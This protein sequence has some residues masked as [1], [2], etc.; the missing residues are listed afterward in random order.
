MAGPGVGKTAL[1]NVIAHDEKVRSNFEEGI[2]WANVGEAGDIFAL[3]QKWA[4][5]LGALQL[6]Q[7]QD[8][9][10]LSAALRSVLSGRDLLIIADDVWTVQQGL[11][12]KNIVDLKTSTLL[13]TTRFTDVARQL[14][15]VPDDIYILGTLSENSALE[16][17]NMLAPDVI[18]IYKQRIPPLIQALEGLPLAL[19]VAGPT[20]QHYYQMHLDLEMLI[21]EFVN[22]YKR[23]LNSLA[24]GDRFDEKTGRT[25]TIELLFKRSVQTLSPEAQQAFAVLGVFQRK[26]GNVCLPRTR[27]CLEDSQYGCSD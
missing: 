15:D 19:R 5:E 10:T 12:I 4:K 25:P 20:L 17:L 9:S 18:K 24:P 21:D 6:Q 23:L 14:M 16:L 22:H 11:L 3:F 1:I 13:L 7:I 8:L 27:R 26:T 2:L